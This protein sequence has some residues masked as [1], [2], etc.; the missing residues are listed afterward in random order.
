[1]RGMYYDIII[2]LLCYTDDTIKQ[3]NVLYKI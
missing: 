2:V 3:M 1:M